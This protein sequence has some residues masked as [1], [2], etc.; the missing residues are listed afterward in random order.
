[1]RIAIATQNGLTKPNT[2]SDDWLTK[3]ELE[4]L[5]IEVD[6]IDWRD[7]QVDLNSYD[8]IFVSSTWNASVYYD[9]FMDWLQSCEEKGKKLI[10]DREFLSLGILKD[11]YLTLL[12]EQ[13][14]ESDS[15]QGS[16][17]PSIFIKPN[18][19][20]QSFNDLRKEL[21]FDKLWQGELVIK[22]I[23]SSRGRDTYLITDNPE[24]LQ[25]SV[26]YRPFKD[27]DGI[28]GDLI[29][30]HSSKGFIIQP[31][32]RNV[33]SNGEYQLVFIDN[34][35]SHAI[36]KGKGFGNRVTAHKKPVADKDLPPGM[37]LF[38]QKIMQYYK[39][40]APHG[41]LRA[42]FD[43]FV[44][45]KGPVLS[46]AEIVEPH[47][48][49][50]Y[51]PLDEQKQILTRYAQA[52]VKR[53]VQLQLQ[54]ILGEDAENYFSML[55]NPKLLQA[56]MKV[57]KTNGEILSYLNSSDDKK[58]YELAKI[59]SANYLKDCL[60]ALNGF[61]DRNLQNKDLLIDS[62]NQ[63]RDDYTK[64]VLGKDRS[65]FSK[66]VRYLLMAVVNFIAALTFGAAHLKNYKK[67]G[68]VGFFTETNSARDLRKDHQELNQ[69]LE[70]S[71]S[72]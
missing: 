5:G 55:N 61:Y 40:Q 50:R 67:N 17:T 57:Y 35:F 20:T 42:R 22:P 30:M 9:E 45:D 54:T 49:I 52:L 41:L 29:K 28:A 12:K 24:L 60:S 8:S 27:L 19:E 13:F 63:A 65:A 59:Y 64:F 15:L 33:E 10:N 14:G 46:E 25:K 11:K 36:S 62:L 2:D 38:A 51:F 3:S 32:I 26:S 71:F 53:N 70:L 7:K 16:I 47:T 31:F 68:V 6:I 34:Q 39:D 69:E 48:N 37:L 58:K 43:F 44:G 1:M 18:E 23:V 21:P 66:T 56:V 72:V 4:K